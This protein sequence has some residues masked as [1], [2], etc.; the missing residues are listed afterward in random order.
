[1]N[2]KLVFPHRFFFL[3]LFMSHQQQKIRY[4]F[5][6]Q[7]HSV[8]SKRM[9]IKLIKN[10]IMKRPNKTKKNLNVLNLKKLK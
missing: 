6:R 9:N 7:Q 3:G 4:R 8:I 5:D 10:Y 1:M 2:G